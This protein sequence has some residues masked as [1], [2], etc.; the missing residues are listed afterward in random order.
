VLV[1]LLEQSQMAAPVLILF[2]VQSHR[3]AAVLEH[4]LVAMVVLVVRV[5]AVQLVALE[6]LIKVLLV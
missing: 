4:K 6:L 2:S 1:V 3:L 5:A